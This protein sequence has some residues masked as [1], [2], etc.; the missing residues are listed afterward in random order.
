MFYGEL[1]TVHSA[2]CIYC[3]VPSLCVLEQ[4]ACAPTSV[5]ISC[6]LHQGS[7]PRILPDR[8]HSLHHHHHRCCSCCCHCYLIIIIIIVIIVAIIAIIIVIIIVIIIIVIIIVITTAVSTVSII[9]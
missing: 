6:S 2:Q 4:A 1:S 7:H 3:T 9:N 5:S 8:T